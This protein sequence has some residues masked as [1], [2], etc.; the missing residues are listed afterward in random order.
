MHPES[1]SNKTPDAPDSNMA[2]AVDDHGNLILYAGSYH[3]TT[4]PALICANWN[5][6]SHYPERRA[7]AEIETL[8]GELRTVLQTIK[9]LAAR[10]DIAADFDPV[11]EWQRYARKHCTLT[12]DYWAG[13]ARCASS[14]ICGPANF[15]VRRMQKRMSW[16]DNKRQAI[17]RHQAQA[18]KAIKHQAY[19]FGA[20]GE[21][22]RSNNPNATEALEEK[23]QRLQAGQQH[24]KAANALWRKLGRPGGKDAQLD[25]EREAWAAIGEAAG[26]GAEAG[27]TTI[28]RG[29]RDHYMAARRPVPP[30]EAYLLSNANAEIRR[31][32]ARIQALQTQAERGAVEIDYPDA[33]CTYREDPEIGRVQLIFE[34]KPAGPAR[35]ILKA[36]GFRWAPSQG[37]WQRHLNDN[38]R[39]AAQCV[40]RQIAA[41]EGEG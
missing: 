7:R 3:F 5:N 36:K 16:Q 20:P 35:A 8:A 22:I 4:W 2:L 25:S 18:L 1:E 32:E 9:D 11:A 24:M 40:Q 13:E 39:R 10:A 38:G 29:C 28:R 26:L 34:G 27:I 19:P 30:F 14:F 15:P 12:L 17:A 37:A 6:L 21:A 31:I 23:R 41:L 33:A